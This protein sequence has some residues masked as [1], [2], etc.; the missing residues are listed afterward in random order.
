MVEENIK[1]VLNDYKEE[2][3]RHF[4]VVAEDLKDGIKLIA[5]Q[6]SSIQD[7][8]KSHTQMMASIKK[9]LK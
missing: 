6:H 5:E 7:I 4:D 1:Q 8:L 2:T 3:K 9:I